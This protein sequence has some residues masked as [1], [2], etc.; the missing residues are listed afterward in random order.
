MYR[1]IC[2]QCDGP[3]TYLSDRGGRWVHDEGRLWLD[4]HD[5]EPIAREVAPA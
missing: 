1:G 4:H 2:A 5:H 3:V